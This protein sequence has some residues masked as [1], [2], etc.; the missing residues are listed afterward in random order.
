MILLKFKTAINGES[1]VASHE[2][3]I[4]VSSMQLGVGRAIASVAGGGDRETS[5]P[6]FSEVTFSKPTNIASAELFMQAVCGKSLGKLE[7]HFIQTGGADKKSQVYLTIEF[8]EPLVSSYSMSS[9]GDRPTE[10]FS[11][12]YTKISY[13]YDKFDGEKITVGTA[14]K[15]DLEKNAVY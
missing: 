3:W 14:K 10:S 5:N 7:C 8:E 6:S 1:T 15:W 4:T 2:K 13:K 11:V 9:G 12:N